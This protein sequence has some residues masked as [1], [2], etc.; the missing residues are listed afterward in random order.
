MF[1]DLTIEVYHENEDKNTGKTIKTKTVY[2]INEDIDD[3]PMSDIP[4]HKYNFKTD[5]LMMSSNPYEFFHSNFKKIEVVGKSI[6]VDNAAEYFEEV[7]ST[8]VK[9]VIYA[10]DMSRENEDFFEE[11]AENY[12]DIKIQISFAENVTFKMAKNNYFPDIKNV[13][14][15]TFMKITWFGEDR[16]KS[17]V[18]RD[19]LK[20]DVKEKILE[21]L[22]YDTMLP[23]SVDLNLDSRSFSLIPINYKVIY[24]DGTNKRIS[25]ISVA[26]LEKTLSEMDNK[27]VAVVRLIRRGLRRYHAY[28]VY[29][30]ERSDKIQRYPELRESREKS[31][32][33]T[34]AKG[35]K[36]KRARVTT[37]IKKIVKSQKKT[38]KRNRVFKY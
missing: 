31:P 24:P 17:A 14:I 36:T 20:K 35:I 25:E 10:T 37:N 18:D 29:K 5:E 8:A 3:N 38:K 2:Y 19:V 1:D 13:E 27:Y 9:I 6:S 11:F 16:Y 4:F 33:L 22:Q 23:D 26:D 32:L 15:E 28:V 21:E 12:P 34:M 7:L 30:G